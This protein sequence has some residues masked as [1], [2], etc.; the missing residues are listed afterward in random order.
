MSSATVFNDSNVTQYVKHALNLARRD[1]E[2]TEHEKSNILFAWLEAE[3]HFISTPCIFYI[4]NYSIFSDIH[5]QNSEEEGSHMKR[6][7]KLKELLC[8]KFGSKG[9]QLFIILHKSVDKI[10]EI[11]KEKK[12]KNIEEEASICRKRNI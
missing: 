4:N 12:R 8:A 10:R 2:I 6:M 3:V 9:L 1:N 7:E 11:V 5:P